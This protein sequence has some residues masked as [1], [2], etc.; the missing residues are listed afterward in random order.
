MKSNEISFDCNVIII[1]YRVYAVENFGMISL[2]RKYHINQGKLCFDYLH[3]R[4]PFKVLEKSQDLKIQ[5][6]VKQSTKVIYH[7][8][9]ALYFL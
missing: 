6:Y 9:V 2:W 8:S 4:K 3:M 5:V 1:F 7:K